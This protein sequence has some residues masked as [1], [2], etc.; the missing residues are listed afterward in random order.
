VVDTLPEDWRRVIDVNLTGAFLTAKVCAAFLIEQGQGGRIIFASSEAGKKGEAGAGAYASSKFA[1]IGLMECLALE[2]ADHNITVNGVCPGMIDSDMLR[3]LAREQ[4]RGTGHTFDE[5]WQEFQE[6][7]P[8]RR[9]GSLKEVADVYLFLASPMAS[10]ITGETIN[11]D[12]GR[13][14]G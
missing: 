9:L 11:V 8:M 5:V 1:I 10:Y 4:A 12:G 13:I 6:V 2:L 3:W 7:V 14:P